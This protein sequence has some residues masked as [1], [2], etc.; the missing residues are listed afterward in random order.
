MPNS[1]SQA[2]QARFQFQQVLI[3]VILVALLTPATSAIA[4][5]STGW[6]PVIV[7]RGEYGR[8]IRSMP[9]PERPGR[10]LHVYGNTIRWRH[11]RRHSNGWSRPMRS[12]FLG[13][14]TVGR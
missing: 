11:Q 14:P 10:P 5:Q 7:P 13:S 9:I 8:K 6:S 2:N 1:Q 4:Q 3:A 12:I